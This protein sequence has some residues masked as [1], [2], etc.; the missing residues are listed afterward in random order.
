MDS[1]AKLPSCYGWHDKLDPSCRRCA[2]RAACIE[3]Q[4]ASRPVCFAQLHD[5]SHPECVRCLDN[6][7]CSEEQQIM[8]A[9]KIRIKRPTDL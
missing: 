3:K 4:A 2:V 7:G 8:V 1:T 6:S 9:P 5:S